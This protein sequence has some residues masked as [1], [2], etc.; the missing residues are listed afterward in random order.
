[1]LRIEKE[2]AEA[3]RLQQEAPPAQL[4]EEEEA[5]ARLRKLTEKEL[6]EFKVPCPCNGYVVSACR[7]CCRYLCMYY[8][9]GMWSR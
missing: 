3:V 4:E 2:L 9:Y 6:T 8:M 7:I 1:M 5:R